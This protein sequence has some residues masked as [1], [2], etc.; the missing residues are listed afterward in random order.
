MPESS[1]HQAS[2]KFSS[3]NSIKSNATA[4]APLKTCSPPSG[5]RV[6]GL[7]NCGI[8]CHFVRDE[9]GCQRFSVIEFTLDPSSKTI[10]NSTCSVNLHH[11]DNIIR[12]NNLQPFRPRTSSPTLYAAHPPTHFHATLTRALFMATSLA[13]HK[14]IVLWLNS[15]PAEFIVNFWGCITQFLSHSLFTQTYKHFQPLL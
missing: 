10:I 11:N 15:C 14:N 6:D 7:F 4:I 12:A 13:Q 1:A 8:Q 3:Q 5:W 2:P 9:L